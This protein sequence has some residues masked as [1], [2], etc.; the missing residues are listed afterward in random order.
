MIAEE[1]V[2]GSALTSFLS[3]CR[4]ISSML[5]KVVYYLRN[6]HM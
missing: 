2:P 5:K 4:K 1:L 3:S 6:F